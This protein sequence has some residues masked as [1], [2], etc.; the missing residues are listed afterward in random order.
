[1]DLFH[2]T[3]A[4]ALEH[5]EA[6]TITIRW[7]PGHSGIPGNEEADMEAKEAARGF[8]SRPTLLPKTLKH[9][10]KPITLPT[11][12]SAVA[13][14]FASQTKALKK[15]IFESSPRA[16]SSHKIDPTLPSGNFLELVDDLPKRHA[17][18][19]FQLRTGHVPLNKHLH[20][21][22]KVDSPKCPHC[23]NAT[24]TVL[25]YLLEC[26][27]Y[28]DA[29]HRLRHALH[30]K[31]RSLPSLLADPKC[32]KPVLAFIHATSRFQTTHG[33]LSPPLEKEKAK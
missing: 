9:K 23:P 21:I 14:T 19:L 20:C 2:K 4:E 17:A 1:M 15:K 13:R 18:I 31:A 6:E 16:P 28:A 29:R 24:K 27:K 25:H 11:S 3:L 12:K 30:R 33:D 7:T 5:M 32:T 10:G 26:P 22:S 8:T